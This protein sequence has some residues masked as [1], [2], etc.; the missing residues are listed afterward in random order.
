MNPGTADTPWVGRL[1]AS[2]ADPEAER[3][4][5]NARQPHGRLVSA[6]R[7][8]TPS[9]TWPARAPARPPA[10]RSPSTAACRNCGCARSSGTR[11]PPAFSRWADGAPHRRPSRQTGAMTSQLQKAELL[12]RLH[13]PGDPLIVT[14]VWDAITAKIVSEAPG[15]TALASA[16][17]S[18]SFAHGVP[19]NEGLTVDDAIRAATDHRRRRGPARLD[20]LREGL[21]PGCRR[22]RRERPPPDRGIRCR[23]HQPRGLAGVGD[24]SAARHRLVG[25]PCRRRSRCRR[26]HRHP[27]GDQRP[28]GHP[29]RRRRLGRGRHA[30]PTP[31]S[32]R[33]PTSSSSSG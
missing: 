18:I 6:T 7:S 30:A 25:G 27:P 8:P 33:A 16:S 19:D 3:A 11:R 22:C 5:L 26:R 32:R 13:A 9:P 12:N 21:R 17:H 14:N 15:V 29:R 24:R 10:R 28:G 1:L 4:A 31:T 2:A 20:R 23:R